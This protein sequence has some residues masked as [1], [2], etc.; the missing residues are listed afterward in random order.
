MSKS[1]DHMNRGF[2]SLFLHSFF[3]NVDKLM[4]VIIWLIIKPSFIASDTTIIDFFSRRLLLLLI[5]DIITD[6]RR[7]MCYYSVHIEYIDAS[8]HFGTVHIF[9][10][11][12]NIFKI[13]Y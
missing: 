5:L 10:T 3:V 7:P 2:F 9:Y 6:G 1:L 11:A 8:M 12:F 13:K 4:R